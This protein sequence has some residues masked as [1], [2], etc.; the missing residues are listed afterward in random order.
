MMTATFPDA[1]RRHAWFRTPP[2][3]S[4]QSSISTDDADTLNPAD[5]AAQA[6]STENTS[7]AESMS[8]QQTSDQATSDTSQIPAAVDRAVTPPPSN[9]T[10]ADQYTP[11]APRTHSSRVSSLI[12]GASDGQGMSGLSVSSQRSDQKNNAQYADIL[13]A[14][15]YYFDTIELLE[16]VTGTQNIKAIEKKIKDDPSVNNEGFK[17]RCRQAFEYESRIQN[18]NDPI[19]WLQDIADIVLLICCDMRLL[20]LTFFGIKGSESVERTTRQ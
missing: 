6:P 15:R 14:H 17:A 20:G 16:R 4:M 18:S 2:N 1:Q 19:G 3:G 11:V 10:A 5:H 8:A 7:L 9:Q 12:S 13:E